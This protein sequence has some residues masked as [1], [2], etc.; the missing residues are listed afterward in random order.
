MA[1]SAITRLRIMLQG[2]ERQL[3]SA[4]RLARFCAQ[5][6]LAEGFEPED[7]DPS[8]KR[9]L[10]VE[11]TARELYDTLCFTGSQNPIVEDV[12]T[13]FGKRLGKNVR[14]A[15]PPGERLNI[16]AEGESGLEP[17]PEAEQLRARHLLRQVIRQLVERS[18]LDAPAPVARRKMEPEK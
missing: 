14:F 15:Y 5:G 12:R 3:L 2:Y 13:E 4:R 8:I 6:R 11:K 7:P 10:F 18:M 1:E 16:V 17:L 9:R